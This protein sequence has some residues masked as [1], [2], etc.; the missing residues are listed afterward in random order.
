MRLYGRR[1]AQRR[2]E[3]GPSFSEDSESESDHK[4]ILHKVTT[5]ISTSETSLESSPLKARQKTLVVVAQDVPGELE[6]WDELF[7][8]IDGSI[9]PDIPK[10]EGRDRETETDDDDDGELHTD[11]SDGIVSRV[12]ISSIL[13]SFASSEVVPVDNESRG[14]ILPDLTPAVAPTPVETCSQAG[15]IKYGETRTHKLQSLNEDDDGDSMNPAQLFMFESLSPVRKKRKIRHVK[16]TA[17][18]WNDYKVNGHDNNNK[19]EATEFLIEGL[20]FYEEDEKNIISGNSILILTL[21]DIANEFQADHTYPYDIPLVL[22]SLDQ[23]LEVLAKISNPTDER[24]IGFICWLVSSVTYIFI[25]SAVEI[26]HAVLNYQLKTIEFLFECLNIGYD[27]VSPPG[28]LKITK[29]YLNDIHRIRSTSSDD[30]IQIKLV[31]LL[32]KHQNFLAT[33]QGF[34]LLVSLYWK[35]KTSSGKIKV[36][37]CIEEYIEYDYEMT[38]RDWIESMFI[39]MVQSFVTRTEERFNYHSSMVFKL[40]VLIST[41]YEPN[42]DFFNSDLI[43]TVLRIITKHL[44]KS[45]LSDPHTANCILFLLGLLLNVVSNRKLSLRSGDINAN[46]EAIMLFA[47]NGMESDV[48]RHVFGYNIMLLGYLRLA[49]NYT[50]DIQFLTLSLISFK[51]EITSVSSTTHGLIQKIDKVLY[52]LQLLVT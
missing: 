19:S 37:N 11:S 48:Q 25:T 18:H 7:D 38:S 28:I 40:A 5:S 46:V 15:I 30:E 42:L 51:S 32:F 31:Y 17:I 22:E 50:V 34:D 26:N 14:S 44:K 43:S 24:N 39:T 20:K 16:N 33:T 41:R 10:V 52:G 29:N 9:V 1:S 4:S 27:D 35:A 8:D 23:L 47:A 6:A 49:I 12:N 13:L 2:K 45:N 36:L 3:N 21:I